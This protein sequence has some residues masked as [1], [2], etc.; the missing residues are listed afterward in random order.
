M[1][2]SVIRG[3]DL[4]VDESA[5][6]GESFPVPKAEGEQISAGTVVVAGEGVSRVTVTGGRTRLGQIA[7]TTREIRPPK[8]RLQLAMKDLAGKLVYISVAVV[9]LITVVGILRGQD[10]GTMFL[11][12]LSLAF[13]T[14]PEE[15]PIIITMVLG[16]GAYQLSRSNFL[17]KKAEGSRD[18]GR[19]DGYCHR[20]DRD[21]HRGGHEGGGDVP[22]SG[23]RCPQGCS[24]RCPGLLLISPG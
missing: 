9:V 21:H 19:Y 20:Q 13:A 24:P 23:E 4:Q 10:P 2:E 22:A 12:G 7:A 5:L 6:T 16:L 11:T 17:V 14:I 1:T 15:L 18:A 8:T 3:I